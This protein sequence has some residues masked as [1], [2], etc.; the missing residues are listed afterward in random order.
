MIFDG[1]QKTIGK[2]SQADVVSYYG[3]AYKIYKKN[4]QT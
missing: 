4:Y 1:T 2:G 3:Y